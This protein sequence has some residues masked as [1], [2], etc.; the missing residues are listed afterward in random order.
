MYEVEH[1]NGYLLARVDS[2][3]RDPPECLLLRTRGEGG[4]VVCSK[5]DPR[6]A[7]ERASARLGEDR[8]ALGRLNYPLEDDG[9]SPADRVARFGP[10]SFWP[11]CLLKCRTIG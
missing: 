10:G 9:Q 6:K 4:G 11:V 5:N 7:R 8:K 1:H 3:V 2:L